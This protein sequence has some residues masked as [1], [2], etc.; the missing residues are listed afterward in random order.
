MACIADQDGQIDY[1][2]FT[3]RY[4]TPA[5]DIGFNLS[6]LLTNLNEHTT[7]DPRLVHIMEVAHSMQEYFKNYL[8]RIEIIGSAKRVERVYF[9]IPAENREQWEQKQ[10][11]E[12][13]D[14]FLHAVIN[15]DGD[16]A[17]LEAFVSFCEDAIFEMQH[18]AEIAV[19]EPPR[20]V[21]AR[22]PG[23]D[24]VKSD[25]VWEITKKG[26]GAVK[27]GVGA[28]VGLLTPGNVKRKYHRL[29]RM[30]YPQLA[31]ATA[32]AVLWMFYYIIYF[33]IYFVK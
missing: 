25:S 31:W 22:P 1:I 14:A 18:A 7:K 23:L 27:R 20:M 16:S 30:T 29:K 33:Q 10:I 3:E 28:V 13:K 11:K 19:K 5:K 6:L 24:V 15:G 2:E 8:G 26:L 32:K 12:S 17:K 9:E 21:K 4:H